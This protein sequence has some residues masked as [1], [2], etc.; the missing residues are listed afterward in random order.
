MLF[1]FCFCFHNS[2]PCRNNRLLIC[3][4]AN[5]RW[6]AK[7][8]LLMASKSSMGDYRRVSKEVWDK[9]CEYYP[10][11]GP[12][13]KSVFVVVTLFSVFIII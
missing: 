12:T 3:D 11:S 13:I 10:G 1:C 9:F 5:S 7:D 2:G 6:K 8:G 4:Y